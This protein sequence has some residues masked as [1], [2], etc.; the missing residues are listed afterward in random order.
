MR[1]E[2]SAWELL[3]SSPVGFQ[4]W[5]RGSKLARLRR[6]Q[7]GKSAV[8]RILTRTLKP[9]PFTVHRF[10]TSF[11][12]QFAARVGLLRMTC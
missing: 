4:L 1:A 11:H 12:P 8:F 3:L 2:V 10:Q 5:T 7:V 9:V 6:K